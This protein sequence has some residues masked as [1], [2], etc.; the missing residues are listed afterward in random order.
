MIKA[1]V[2]QKEF[3]VESKE[4]GW[5][6]NG[7]PFSWDIVKLSDNNFHILYQNKSYRAEIVKIEKSSKTVSIK[8]NNRLHTVSVKDKFDLL[9]ET[10]GIDN[11]ASSKLNVIKAPMPGLIIDLKV[12][13]GDQVEAG[14]SLLILEAMKMENVIKSPGKG[15]VKT[16]K[17]AKGDSVERGQV[18][19]E[20]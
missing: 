7:E 11:Q 18:L 16:V 4:N 6:V 17:A 20:F 5:I 15:K 14:D 8:I 9:L 19:I 1:I 12:K 13:V 10:M 2:D 3:I